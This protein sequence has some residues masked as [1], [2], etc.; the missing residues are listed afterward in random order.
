MSHVKR[1]TVRITECRCKRRSSVPPHFLLQQFVFVPTGACLEDFPFA[2]SLQL[3]QD[4]EFWFCLFPSN[5]QRWCFKY[6]IVH[7]AHVQVA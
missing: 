7:L 1:K 6:W 4:G 5:C 3:W 2:P